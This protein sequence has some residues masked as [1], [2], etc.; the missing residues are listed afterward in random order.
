MYTKYLTVSETDKGFQH[1]PVVPIL[2]KPREHLSVF[3]IEAGKHVTY[4]KILHLHL[5]RFDLIGQKKTGVD[6]TGLITAGPASIL[7]QQYHD[8]YPKKHLIP[9]NHTPEL[10]GSIN[11]LILYIL[12]VRSN[13]LERVRLKV[14]LL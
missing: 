12:E 7:L 11:T 1:T 13:R 3:R 4:R 8:F 14:V 2:A 6:V 10:A 5:L 9:E